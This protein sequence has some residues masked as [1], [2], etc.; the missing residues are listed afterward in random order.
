MVSTTRN[1]RTEK[2]GITLPKSLLRTIEDKRRDIPRST[3]IRRAIENYLKSGG[4]KN[5]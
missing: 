2:L 5:V 1:D 3:Y 4:R